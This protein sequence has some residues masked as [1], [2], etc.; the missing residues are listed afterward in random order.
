VKRYAPLSGIVFV[1]L[2]IVAFVVLGG[3]TPGIGKPPAD[4]AS[5]YAQHHDKE[6]NAA[7]V[8]ALATFFLALFVASSWMLIRDEGQV[9]SAL[10]F[11]GGMVAVAVFLVAASIHLALADGGDHNLDPV[12]LQALNALDNDTF[13]GFTSVGIMLLGAAGAMIPRQAVLK[14]LGWLALVI[15]IAVFTPVGFV[16][17]AGAGIWII[18]TSIVLFRQAGGREVPVT[19]AAAA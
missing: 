18:A 13:V 7:F 10:F 16:A 9:W 12:A 8:L 15:G 6:T 5:F 4:V 3:S 14:W 2:F 17:F 11:G 19:A 1:V